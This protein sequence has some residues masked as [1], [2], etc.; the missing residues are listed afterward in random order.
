MTKEAIAERMTGEL[1][2]VLSS[3][4]KQVIEEVIDQYQGHL[5][6]ITTNKDKLIAEVRAERDIANTIAVKMQT[7]L[8]MMRQKIKAPKTRQQKATGRKRRRAA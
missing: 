3:F 8:L 1:Y 2:R 4:Q 7:E 5:D 6:S